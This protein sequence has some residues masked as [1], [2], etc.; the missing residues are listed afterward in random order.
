MEFTKVLP[1]HEDLV[2]DIAF[3]YYG[4]RFAT[5]SSDKH[6]KI[7]TLDETKSGNN[8]SHVDI[9]RAHRDSIWRLSW[10]NPEFGQVLASCSE[11]GVICVWEEQEASSTQSLDNGTSGKWVRK[12]R[13][14]NSK[15]SVN[16]VKFSNRSLGI[17]LATASAD[18]YIRIYEA[19]DVFNLNKW[20]VLLEYQVED[21]QSSS[22]ASSS[23]SEHGLTCLAWCDCPFE[24]AKI[25]VGGYSRR[26]V[27]FTLERNNTLKVECVLG[28]HANAV[29]D[30]AWAPSMGRSYHLICTASREPKFYI[31]TLRRK[32]DGSLELQSVQAMASTSGSN[33]WRVAWN[34]TGTVLATS[35]EDGTL[36]LWRKN[37]AGTWINVQD[38]PA[39]LENKMKYFYRN[40]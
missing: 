31:H 37:F 34:A 36:S 4:E 7:W 24:P 27:V 23:T 33:V 5:C 29:H 32:A 26:A 10:A 15:K 1:A 17:K 39:N 21:T 28:E 9:S 18:G 6:I 8:W 19:P 16:D 20:D 11:D 2:H 30:I 13:L 25:A 14:S 40:P 12:V 22:S 35:S 3:D 38:I